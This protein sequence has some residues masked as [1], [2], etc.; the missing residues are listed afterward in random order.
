MYLDLT[1]SASFLL[2]SVPGTETLVRAALSFT[3][4]DKGI[5]FEHF[6]V[7]DSLINSPR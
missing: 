3:K 2:A 5:N 7:V 1:L 6:S 4:P